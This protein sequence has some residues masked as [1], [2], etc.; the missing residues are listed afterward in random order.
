MITA[1]LFDSIIVRN[2]ISISEIPHIQLTQL[3][4]GRDDNIQVYFQQIKIDS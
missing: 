3:F 4:G 2:E 1:E